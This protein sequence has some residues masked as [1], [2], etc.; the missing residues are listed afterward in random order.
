MDTIVR[1]TEEGLTLE[2]TPKDINGRYLDFKSVSPFTHKKNTVI[3][4]VD[5]AIKLSDSLYRPDSLDT[6]RQILN[7]NNYPKALVE[8]TIKERTH[9]MYNSLQKVDVTL[10]YKFISTPYVPGLGEK[11]AKYLRQ[12]NITLA[13]KPIDKIKDHVFTK[14]KDKIDKQKRT[15]VVYEIPC[16]VCE[17]KT[18]IGQTSQFLSKRLEQHKNDVKTKK[19]G[20]TGLV[21]HT[22]N[23][24]HC[25]N[26]DRTKILNEIPRTDTRLIAETFYIKIKGEGNTVNLQRD[27]IKFRSAYNGLIDKLKVGKQNV[28][29]TSILTTQNE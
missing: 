3:A 18:Y 28:Q 9:N 12:F 6:V 21:Q 14:L 25:F 26:F 16:G 23:E 17:Y 8:R 20:S 19:I 1:R 7:N 24:G 5:R 13:F 11:I 22:I 2:W 27:S 29:N 10:E 15:N 4:L